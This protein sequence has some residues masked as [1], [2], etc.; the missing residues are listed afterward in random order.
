MADLKQEL[1]THEVTVRKVTITEED[2][3]FI[4]LGVQVEFKDGEKGWKYQNNKSEKGLQFMRKTLKAIG[5]D[6]DKNDLSH[7]AG[8]PEVLNGVECEA[9]VGENDWNGKITNR[10][11]WINPIRKKPAAEKLAGL[12]NALRNVKK[13]DEEEVL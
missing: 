2:G 3:G 13:Q 1:G 5:F 12:T 4:T 10:I 7:L 11:D 6:P 8:N 9:V